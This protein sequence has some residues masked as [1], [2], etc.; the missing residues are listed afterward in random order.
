M[1]DTGT[2]LR[3]RAQPSPR[4]PDTLRFLLDAP[5]QA[6]AAAV[7]DRDGDADAPLARALLAIAA[8]QRVEVEG[9][10]IHV[11][12]AADARWE[13]LKAP[14]AA[15]IR[16]VMTGS[17][18]P[19]GEQKIED[20]DARMLAAVRDL[21]DTRIN[22]SIS[23]HGGHITAERVKD[24]TVYL[25][26]SGGCQGCA[27]SQLT[28]RGGVERV[29][30]GALPDLQGIVDVTD[31]DSG[32]APFHAKLPARQTAAISP[33]AEPD[34]PL[35]P[36]LRS[37]LESLPSDDSVVGYGTLTRDM[38]FTEPGSIRLVT[39]ALEE[40]MHE[41]AAAGRPFIAARA[42]SRAG[43]GLPGK[44]FFD[45]A[46]HLSRGPTPGESDREF[47]AREI[48]RLSSPAKGA[49]S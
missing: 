3:I 13:D 14:I 45:L 36:R 43:N 29:L 37:Y 30:R 16:E 33:V 25:H 4:D 8:V 5:V 42:V 40:T 2:R 32:A 35:A 41:D 7:F 38:G 19:L 44:G 26:M 11:R 27:A 17:E 46:C 48:V 34:T 39:D 21:L 9:E 6:H 28:L 15:A 10:S 49:A 12:K 20:G 1:S 18:P 47:H 24:G 22:P 31:H 23:S